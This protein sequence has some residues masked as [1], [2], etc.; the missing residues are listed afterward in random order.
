MATDLSSLQNI[1]ELLV[2]LQS[3]EDAI[4]KKGEKL[5]EE[6][7][8]G[9]PDELVS[10]LTA[11]LAA[12]DATGGAPAELR[13]EAAVLL[14]QC[15]VGS[16]PRNAVFDDL[17]ATTQERLKAELLASVQ[18]DSCNPVRRNAGNAA[19]AIA[20]TLGEDCEDLQKA[21]PELLPA[22][23]RFVGAE[24]EPATRVTALGVLKQLVG[25]IGE[26]LLAQGAVVMAMLKTCLTDSTPEVRAACAQLVFQLVEDLE[27]EKAQVLGTVMPEAIAALASFATGPTALEEPLKETLEA[28]I[29]A[30]DEEPEFFKSNG[31][32]Q[33]W[34]LLLQLASAKHFAEEEVRHSAMEAAMSFACGL[35]EDFCKAEGLP[36]LEQIIAL[37]VEWM[38]EV[39]EDVESWTRLAD[40]EDDD[41]LD[42]DVVQL[43]EENLDRLAER[44]AEDK[45]LEEVFMPTLFKVIRAVLLQDSWKHARSSIMAVSQVVEHLEEEPWIDQCVELIV[46]LLEHPHPRVR[47]SGFQA[48]GQVAYDHEPYVQDNHSDKLLPAIV[49]ALDDK[50]IRVATNAASAFVSLG[51]DLDRDDL[52]PHIDDLMTR[53][54]TRLQAGETRTMM[55]Q[56]LA[57][58]AAVGG[59]A[60]EHFQPYYTHVMPALKHII[61]TKTAEP[62][63][64]LRGKAFECASLIGD[65]VGKELFLADA[66]EVMQTMMASAQAGFAADDQTREYVHEAAG[67]IAST[68]GRDF[69][70]FMPSL[71]PGIFGVLAQRP[72]E[73]D[74]AT[75]P[76][77]D[78]EDDDKQDMS[79]TMVGDKVVGLKTTV[80]EE[81]KESLVLISTLIEALEDD[82]CDFLPGTCQTLLPMLDFPLSED[83]REKTYK[84]WEV[85]AECARAAAECGKCD[86]S[87]VVE[88]VHGFLEATVT[89]MAKVPE[90]DKLGAQALGALEAQATGCSG[91]VRKAGKGVLTQEDVLSLSKVLFDLLGRVT[92]DK[93]EPVEMVGRKNKRLAKSEE[94]DDEGEEEEDTPTRQSVRFSLADVAGALIRSN[95]A[96]FVQA[97]LP[98]FMALVQRLL[99]PGTG[100]AD[101]SL[102]LY[103]CEDVVDCLGELSIPYWNTFMEHAC[104]SI[105]DKC[106]AIRQYS[107][108]CMGAGAR[109]AIFSQIAPLAAAQLARLLQ[110]HGERH[111]RR[112]AANSEAKQ[113]ALGVDACIRALGQVCEHQEQHIGG[114]SAAAWKLWLSSLP[115][116][117]DMEEGH[118]AHRQLL[119]LVVK[120][121]PVITAPEQL[122]KTLAVFADIYRTKFSDAVL[123]KELAI[124]VVRA[125]TEFVQSYA[126]GLPERQQK[127]VEQMVKDGQAAAA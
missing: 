42:D 81:M 106:P 57:G 37:N 77:E 21:W 32:Q 25:T 52:E 86:R 10:Q 85:M 125:G 35:S 71:L 79:F 55:E 88:L 61:A 2:G 65:A 101:R 87:V 94:D 5:L 93:D 99:Q 78:D 108:G 30:A 16:G 112:R 26:G 123:D 83:V 51:E 33:L 73:V 118:K 119:E 44:C 43:G 124:A 107:C 12:R 76:D 105:T 96:E 111:R 11:V 46:G 68:L 89:L 48:V 22:L 84:T 45:T 80:L 24:S 117:Y 121:H 13:Q 14:R 17:A 34:P 9:S 58:I 103:L 98:S 18:L 49:K 39:E 59:V 127:K 60:E 3:P 64:M 6:A 97:G 90:G 120:G 82:F 116:R 41:E 115:M 74:P 114:D 69:K 104:R 19:A 8:K 1:C 113:V 109:Q 70:P 56:C 92:T 36:L 20:E 7:L 62:E 102:A 47:Y 4:R 23:S 28:L 91:V 29:S 72:Q 40:E 63:R 50:N 110:K 15:G 38:L 66:R 31:L 75:L 122:P 53:F 67:R 126:G 27:E 54:F 100:D 95:Q